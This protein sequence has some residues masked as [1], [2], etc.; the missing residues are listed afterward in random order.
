MEN[1]DSVLDMYLF[2]TNSLLDQLDDILLKAESNLSFDKECMDEIFRI[3]HTIKGSS[4]MMQFDGIMTISHKIEDLFYYIRENGIDQKYNEGLVNLVFKITDFIKGEIVKVEEGLELETNLGPLKDEIKL[5][6]DSIKKEGKKEI[7]EDEGNNQAKEFRYAIRIMFDDEVSMENVRAFIIVNQLRDTGIEFEYKPENIESIPETS[8]EIIEKG[9]YIY[10]DEESLD[11]AIGVISKA[12]NVKNYTVFEYNEDLHNKNENETI[13]GKASCPADLNN[14][15]SSTNSK[16]CRQSLITV[17]LSKL[18]KLVDIVGELVIAESMVE[19]DP[20]IKRLNSDSFKKSTRQMRKLTDELQDIVMSLRMVPISGTFNKMHRIVRD[21]GKELNK[22]VDLILNGEDTEIDKTIADSISDPIMHLVRN[23]MD[24]GIESEEERIQAGKNK[25][26]II[27]LSAFNTGGEIHI[28][29]E[30]DFGLDYIITYDGKYVDLS[31]KET[32]YKHPEEIIYNGNYI[33]TAV[34]NKGNRTV[35]NVVIKSKRKL[36]TTKF[37]HSIDLDVHDYKYTEK[38]FE[39]KGLEYV[40]PDDDLKL[41]ENIFPAYMSGKNADKFSPDAPITRAEVVTI[42]CRLND[43]PYDNSAYLKSKFTDISNHWARDYIS[44]GSSKRYVSGYKDKTFKPDNY[45]TR[46][47]FCQM[48]TKISSYKTLLNAI[49]ASSNIS[50]TDIHNHWAEK[51]IIKI[52][53]RNLVL[54]SSDKF[55]P[56]EPITRSEVVYAVNTLYG[57]NP[58]YSELA[59]INS[60]YNKYYNFKDIDN[61]K[62]YYHIIISVI[63]MY[64]EVIN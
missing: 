21:M 8:Q 49:P 29:V 25:K 2:E 33:F 23:A 14:S 39:N 18:D 41:F 56:D 37:R 16:Q 32:E 34:D 52:A 9:F 51:E 42:F 60:L 44:M 31:G 24:H 36:T 28:T 57:F 64:R 50:Y 4:A 38:L 47:E 53:G 61:H 40:K 6:L 48:L 13:T 55:Y 3:M 62:Y 43:L 17:N 35:E 58:S 45:I 22:D 10:V 20:D 19:S 26:G 59:Y 54:G 11:T 1:L 63:G 30:D 7:S 46:A 15:M 5:F 27:T 12:L